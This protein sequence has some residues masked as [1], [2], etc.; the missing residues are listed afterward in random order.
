MRGKISE[1]PKKENKK[2]SI[3][4]YWLE[5]DGKLLLFT[6][7]N[8]KINSPE[9]MNC[10]RI[11]RRVLNKIITYQSIGVRKT[12]TGNVDYEEILR[13]SNLESVKDELDDGYLWA[14]SK[15]MKDITLSGPIANGLE[16]YLKRGDKPARLKLLAFLETNTEAK[17]TI[18]KVNPDY[19]EMKNEIVPEPS[20]QPPP[21]F[22]RCEPKLPG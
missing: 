15:K 8:S 6:D 11:Y 9:F 14:D 2:K 21:R 22:T 5:S 12:P 10:Q 3:K 20:P 1:D 18:T 7:L 19:A 13:I 16:R 17:V 4:R